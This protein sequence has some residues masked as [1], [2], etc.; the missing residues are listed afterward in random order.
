MSKKYR[1]IVIFLFFLLVVIIFSIFVYKVS[2]NTKNS[3][4]QPER[5]IKKIEI[6]FFVLDPHS[7]KIKKTEALFEFED[8]RIVISAEVEKFKEFEHGGH[9]RERKWT[10]GLG[11]E[12][13][14]FNVKTSLIAISWKG[15]KKIKIEQ[16]HLIY[17]DDDN[18]ISDIDSIFK[19][20]EKI[21]L[22]LSADLDTKWG[23]WA[24]KWSLEER[25]EWKEDGNNTFTLGVS[26]D[27]EIITP[28][29]RVKFI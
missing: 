25:G 7:S 20:G 13:V 12:Q 21:E 15:G 1:M 26:S 19:E 18:E 16:I 4:K 6:N 3:S 27:Y 22:R 17:K 24:H 5:Q 2:K 9:F 29:Q 11:Y 8:D 10:D 28:T 14:A 23:G